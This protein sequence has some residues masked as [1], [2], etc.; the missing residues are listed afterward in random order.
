MPQ[1]GRRHAVGVTAESL[2]RS[3][4]FASKWARAGACLAALA[5]IS[6]AAPAA[7]RAQ[8]LSPSRPPRPRDRRRARPRSAPGRQRAAVSACCDGA[9][10]GR[11]RR[12]HADAQRRA[13]GAP[14]RDR[15]R[16]RRLRREADGRSVTAPVAPPSAPWRSSRSDATSRSGRRRDR[17]IATGASSP[18]ASSRRTVRRA[19]NRRAGRR[20]ALAAARLVAQG[21]ARLAA[22]IESQ[23]CLGELRARERDAAARAWPLGRPALFCAERRETGRHSQRDGAGSA[24]SK[25]RSSRCGKSGNDL[26]QF[27]PPLVGKLRRCHFE[28]ELKRVAGRGSRSKATEGTSRGSARILVELRGGPRIEVARPEQIAVVAG[29]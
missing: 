19:D 5:L 16:A 18:S 13:R 29:R 17:P 21:H 12:A 3:A 10:Q 25:A 22:R 8:G 23:A 28:A 24:W 15:G 9:R 27:R 2:I 1:S 4:S 26:H 20:R 7:L 14:R 11:D 6:A